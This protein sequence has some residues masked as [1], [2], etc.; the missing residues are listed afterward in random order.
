MPEIHYFSKIK[1]CFRSNRSTPKPS[2][3]EEPLPV[4]QKEEPLLVLQIEEPLPVLPNE[5]PPAHSGLFCLFPEH[6]KILICL[7]T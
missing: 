1:N 2:V 4:L 3:N 6:Q 7:F 5:E